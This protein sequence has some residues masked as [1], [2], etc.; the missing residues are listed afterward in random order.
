VALRAS[1]RPAR[2]RFRRSKLARPTL[3]LEWQRWVADNLLG[4]ASA[5]ELS[6]ELV[7]RGVPLSLARSSV[8]EL[9]R[10]PA[11]AAANDRLR[12][13][14]QLELVRHLL[15]LQAT[16]A[17]NPKGIERRRTPSADEL[18]DRYLA[19]SVPA[20]FTDLVPQWPAFKRWT[21]AYFRQHFGQI[22]VQITDA[23]E[24]DPDYDA[25]SE[26]HARTLT[27][28]ELVARM[29][30]VDSSNDFYMVAKNRNI[31]RPELAPLFED[32]VLPDGWFRDE[33]RLGS[34]ALWFG[35]A[36][37]V[38]PLHHDASSILFCQVHGRKRWRMAS[39]LE[40][41]LLDGARAMYSAFDPEQL[42]ADFPV[43]FKD[44]VLEPGEALF[45][46]AGWWHHVR[47]LDVSISLGMN[48][49]VKDNDFDSWYTPGNLR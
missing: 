42:P 36:G 4:G 19:P 2:H 46:P 20:I 10:H 23:R 33:Q 39:P 41:R 29:E 12:G 48:H 9:A 7:R 35:P 26:Q 47:A 43:T 38:T 31:T 13:A 1:H 11:L 27:M 8:N 6:D 37:T 18:F 21:P 14:R 49:F 15:S 32:I 34:S 17:S 24:Q 22:S 16:L 28:N 5:T 40:T 25:R 45:I 30:E 3:A 44:F